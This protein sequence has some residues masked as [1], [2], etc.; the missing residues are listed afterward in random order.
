MNSKNFLIKQIVR[1]GQITA[2]DF[3]QSFEFPEV[4]AAI[5][6]SLGL[7]VTETQERLDKSPLKINLD[8]FYELSEC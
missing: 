7:T 5:A 3:L 1:K 6:K 8:I 4:Q 2:E